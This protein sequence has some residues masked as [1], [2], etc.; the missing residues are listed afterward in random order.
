M[1]ERLI[2]IDAG[3]T[4][5]K[6]V[7]FDLKGR[8]LG[9]ECRPN[10]MLFSEPGWTERDADVMWNATCEAI[11]D[12]LA[13]TGTDPGDI[14]AVTPSGYGGG[15]YLVDAD[16]VPVRNG[17]VSTDSR[18]L[19]LIARWQRSGVARAV[20]A[21]IEQQIW[22]GQSFPIMGWMQENEPEALRRTRHVLFCKD[23]LRLRLTG[24]VSTDPTDAGCAGIIRPSTGMIATAAFEAAGMTAWLDRLPEIGPSAALVGGISA[25]AARL[26]GLRAGTP[27]ARGVYDVVGCALASGVERPDQLAAVAGTFSI[28]STVHA[29]PSL[30]PLPTI[31]T[32]YPVA[33]QFLATMA[34]P[35]SASNLEWLIKTML[36]AEAERSHETGRSIYDIVNDL[37][38]EALKKDNRILFFP[39]LFGGPNGAPA[40]FLGM[41]AGTKLGDTLRAIYEG[42][43][44]AHR[45]DLSFLLNGPDAAKP[46]LIRLAGGP[47]RST[48]WS[49]MFADGLGM[50][51]EVANGTEFGAKGGAICAAVATGIYRDVPEAIAN[52]VEVER[53]YAPNPAR[54]AVLER[55][56]EAYNRAI[57][58]I[59]P[60]WTDGIADAFDGVP[61]KVAAQ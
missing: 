16:G 6:V 45:G 61:E 31:Q 55:K 8:E 36:A 56:Y 35:T 41:T 49:Q 23:F 44:F 18:T 19:P 32:P 58:C 25:E 28:H 46:G 60:Y 14:V 26:T 20:S 40:G 4:M 52:M 21:E 50:P 30:D 24:D 1:R 38:G 10:I 43:V 17:L 47:S 27:V 3:G 53:A 33:G 48:V 9:R 39:F 2:G 7:L 15:I 13:A 54:Q 11:R 37:V 59:A 12:L 22:A 29:R 57:D 42:I 51:V 34:T 5:T